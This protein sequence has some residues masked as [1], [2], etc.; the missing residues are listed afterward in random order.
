MVRQSEGFFNAKLQKYFD[1]FY[2]EYSETAEFYVN[3]EINKWR[4]IIRELGLNILLTCDDDG[5]IVERREVW[6]E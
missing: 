6:N 1:K 2:R 4:F 5:R 3:P